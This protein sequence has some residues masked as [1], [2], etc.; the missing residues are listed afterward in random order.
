MASHLSIFSSLTLQWRHDGH[1]SVSNHQHNNCLLNLLFRRRSKK[2]SKQRVTGHC[3]GNSPGTGEFPAQMASNAEN[4]S[5]WWRHHDLKN[6][7]KYRCHSNIDQR[8]A[9]HPYPS[10]RSKFLSDILLQML[11]TV[12]KHLCRIIDCY[13]WL[14]YHSLCEILGDGLGN[15]SFQMIRT[16]TNNYCFHWEIKKNLEHNH[17]FWTHP[18]YSLHSCLIYIMESLYW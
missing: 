13:N 12:I 3:A 8:E 16:R 9:H 15:F 14:E 1:D 4:V 18:K 5:I 10:A 11:K 7:V 6:C 2:T 17:I